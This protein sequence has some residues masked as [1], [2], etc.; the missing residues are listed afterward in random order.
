[1]FTDA[2]LLTPANSKGKLPAVVVFHPTVS[3]HTHQVA[4][5]DASD[6]EKMHGVPLVLRG[7]VV[8]C[9]RCFIFDEGADYAEN[10]KWMQARHPGWTGMARMTWDGLRAADDLESLPQVDAERIGCLGHSL[11][12]KESLEWLNHR[13]G[14]RYPPAAR[15]AAEEFLDRHVK[16]GKK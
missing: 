8:L 3:N 5:I 2:Y 6:P 1:M 9:P 4:G 16:R 13:L 7:Y 14:H 12:A 11:G 15:G 10:V